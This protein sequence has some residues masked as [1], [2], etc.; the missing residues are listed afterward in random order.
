MQ[1]GFPPQPP[2]S[3]GGGPGAPPGGCGPNAPQP[4]APGYGQSAQS[5]WGIP[6]NPQVPG[7]AAPPSAYGPPPQLA[8]GYGQPYPGNAYPQAGPV[9]YP[10][11]G[12]MVPMMSPFQ[13]SPQAPFGVHP[14]LGIPYSDKSKIAAGLLQVF[15]GTFGVGRFYTGHVGLAVAQLATCFVGVWIL[16]WFTCGLSAIVV[17]WP[18]IDGIVLLASNSTDA[19][20]RL[21]R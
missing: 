19:E 4:Q 7:P 21:L 8:G 13:V 12:A 16:S 3:P 17:F 10:A 1:G 15:V 20:G 11:P 5:P 14:T 6:A 2:G 9:G 18:L